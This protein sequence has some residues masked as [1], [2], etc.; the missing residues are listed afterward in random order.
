[1]MM[2]HKVWQHVVLTKLHLSIELDK[3]WYWN[4]YIMMDSFVFLLCFY[5][6]SSPS[7]HF[8]FIFSIN[9]LCYLFNKR[10]HWICWYS[11]TLTNNI[12]HYLLSSW[13]LYNKEWHQIY[14]FLLVINLLCFYL[15]LSLFLIAPSFSPITNIHCSLLYPCPS[16]LEV[17]NHL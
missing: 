9:V 12:Y 10:W 5:L 15:S 1:M 17:I 8:L 16:L 6:Q 3:T 7:L 13:C 14:L 2:T 11:V 4:H